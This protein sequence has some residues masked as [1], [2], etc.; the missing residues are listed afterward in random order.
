MIGR[1]I[2]TGEPQTSQN[3]LADPSMAPWAE[4]GK[5]YGIA[6]AVDLP[7]K[8]RSGV[9][10]VLRIYA[11]EPNAFD[12]AELRLLQETADDLAYTKPAAHLRLFSKVRDTCECEK[13]KGRSGNGCKT[14][15]PKAASLALT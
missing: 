2:R 15:M 13:Q 14:H 11:A 10:A 7:L 12:S 8:D 5:E 1:A 9:F 3:F 4:V 6:S